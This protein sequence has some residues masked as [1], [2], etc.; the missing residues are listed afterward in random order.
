MIRMNLFST[1]ITAYLIAI[2]VAA[3]LCFAADKHRAVH[4]RWRIKE[5]TLMGLCIAGGSAGGL[6]GMYV[7]RHKTRKPLFFIGVPLV[8]ILQTVL[9]IV[10]KG[11][12]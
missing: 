2:N 7:F 6:A 1:V 12:L 5:M 4:K 3:F 8:L 11:C 9:W 10:V